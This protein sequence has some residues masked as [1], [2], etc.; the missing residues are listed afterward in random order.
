MSYRSIPAAILTIAVFVFTPLRVFGSAYK[1][2]YNFNA[3]NSAPSSGLVTDAAGNA[4]GATYKGGNHDSGTVYEI[5]PTTGFHTIFRFSRNGN[6]GRQ[7]MGNLVLDAAGNLY[8]T[9]F[10]GG[11]SNLCG[12]C[13]GTVFELTPSNDGG[14]WKEI[15]L[16]SFCSLADCTDGAG[17]MA[18]VIFDALGN[19][20]GTTQMGGPNI[21]G[22]VFKLSPSPS[23]WT[24]SVLHGFSG[25]NDGANP[26]GKL[27]FDST[28]NLY[29]TTTGGG[30]SGSG[31]IVFE[32]SPQGDVWDETILYSFNPN[33]DDGYSPK[34]GVTF[35]SAGN[36][37]GTTYLG[38]EFE[39]G[40]VFELS[41]GA[42]G[43]WSE[44]ILHSFRG[45]G[46]DGPIDGSSPQ[47]NII[48]DAEGNLYGTT[49]YGGCLGDACGSVFEVFKTPRRRLVKGR[50]FGFPV[51]G[52][53]GAQ[54]TGYLTFDNAGNIYGTTMV[55]GKNNDGVVF[56]IT[57]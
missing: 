17:P 20:Y 48:I 21:G 39:L 34:A 38:G 5:S 33:D 3:K 16:Y 52:A 32:L 47:S 11:A 54:P 28:G 26:F 37:Y 40:T 9:T 41:P 15:V 23:G 55:G 36:L 30:I 49:L 31:G 6:G 27:I 14:L 1:V 51:G 44:Q 53:L 2:L 18:G 56:R 50:L 45:V 57:P 25:S 24:E 29:G 43:I 12:G 13:G 4:Y 8:G 22:T 46:E 35:D 42:G 19:L 7:P 10:Y